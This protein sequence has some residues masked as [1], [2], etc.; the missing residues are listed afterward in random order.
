MFCHQPAV[1]RDSCW[2]WPASNADQLPGFRVP[3]EP[4]IG[5]RALHGRF[6]RRHIHLAPLRSLAA[7]AP[8]QRAVSGS[9][10]NHLNPARL[11]C[12]TCCHLRSGGPVS[13]SGLQEGQD[14]ENAAAAIWRLGYAEF[15][16][17]TAHM[18]LDRP[19]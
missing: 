8:A 4:Q 2:R 7:A 12:L 6:H 17:D 18:R 10:P 11:R 14:G 9:P 5:R 3:L 19:G 13:G 16:E 15:H 1:G